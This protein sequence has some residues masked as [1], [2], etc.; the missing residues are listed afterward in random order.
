MRY[1]AA[2]ISLL[3]TVP[4]VIVAAAPNHTVDLMGDA[5]EHGLSKQPQG[6]FFVFVFCDGALGSNIGVILSDPG[7]ADDPGVEPGSWSINQ[8]F[9][10]NGPWVLDVTSLAWDPFS[11]RLFVAT[12]GVYGDGGVFVLDLLHKTYDRIYSIEDIDPQKVQSIAEKLRAEA[13]YGYIEKLSIEERSISVSIRL[14]YGDAQ[15]EVIGRR[16]LRLG[17]EQ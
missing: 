10:Q 3:L 11:D 2:V 13:H 17:S 8:R 14:V 15:S 6:H 4:G 5:C 7:V 9:W 12:S 1:A 16:R